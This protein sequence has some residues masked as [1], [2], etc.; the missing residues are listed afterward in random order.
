MGI[1]SGLV[2]QA[3]GVGHVHPAILGLPV[4][5]R[6]LADAV[7]AGQ[8]ARLRPCLVLAQNRDDLIFR[9]PLPLHQSVLQSRPDSNSRW[10]KNSEAGQWIS[11]PMMRM[12]VP[13]FWLGQGRELA[14]NTTSTDP[15]SQR[16]RESREGA[17]M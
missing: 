12:P 7:P 14:G 9:E 8:I 15:R 3:L 4:I 1:L 10:R 5:E 6:R 16:I 13:P 2:I 11:N 17:A